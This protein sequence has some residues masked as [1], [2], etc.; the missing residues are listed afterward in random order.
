MDAGRWGG[1]G[2]PASASIS[3][4]GVGSVSV[5]WASG[6]RSGAIGVPVGVG[7]KVLWL[8][9]REGG[10]L[11]LVGAGDVLPASWVCPLGRVWGGGGVE[12]V[13]ECV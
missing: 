2:A 12:G 4:C 6:S 7:G 3:V 8:S 11:V 13:A 1:G 10:M 5:G 9:S